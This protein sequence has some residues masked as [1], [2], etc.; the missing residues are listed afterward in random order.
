[1]NKIN[2]LKNEDGAVV[3]LGSGLEETMVKYF[4]NLF[5]ATDTDFSEVINCV[6]SRVNE[7]QNVAMLVPVDQKKNEVCII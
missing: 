4:S 6:F 3:E 7:D 1:M 2:S 5:I